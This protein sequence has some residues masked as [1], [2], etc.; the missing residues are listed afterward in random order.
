MITAEEYDYLEKR[1]TVIRKQER[2]IQKQL[3]TLQ[4]ERE[5][6]ERKIQEIIVEDED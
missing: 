3:N 4:K 2:E 6:I 1:W 5:L